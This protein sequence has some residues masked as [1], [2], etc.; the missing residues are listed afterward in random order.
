MC[1]CDCC[2]SILIVLM[3]ITTI[4]NIIII[5]DKFIIFIINMINQHKGNAT[6]DFLEYYV[7][8]LD[9]D[10]K[11]DV[12]DIYDKVNDLNKLI[13]VWDV[14]VYVTNF[15]ICFSSICKRDRF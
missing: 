13:I 6:P 1:G 14:L 9:E 11:F 8:C 12:E 7:Y 2:K 10:I 3:I 5:I 4:L 15:L